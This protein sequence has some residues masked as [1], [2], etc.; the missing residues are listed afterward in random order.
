MDD[1]EGSD[2]LDGGAGRDELWVFEG[3]DRVL[4]GPDNDTLWVL[5]DRRRD[6]LNCGKGA[7][8]SLVFRRSREEGPAHRMCST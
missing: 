3:R 2:V 1:D 5:P 7:R 6:T 8:Q 4:A